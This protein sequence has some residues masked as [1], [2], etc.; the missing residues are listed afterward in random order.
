MTTK[1]V[2]ALSLTPGVIVGLFSEDAASPIHWDS[3]YAGNVEDE[4][5]AYGPK[6]AKNG[7][8]LKD[9]VF[10]VPESP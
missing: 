10:M 3:S 9:D 6:E 4:S 5:E 1:I 8:K 7:A 2:A